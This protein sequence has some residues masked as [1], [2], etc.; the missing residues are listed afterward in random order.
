MGILIEF[1]LFNCS[2]SIC[3]SSDYKSS[4]GNKLLDYILALAPPTRCNG[5][6]DSRLYSGN[7]LKGRGKITKKCKLLFLRLTIYSKIQLIWDA[8]RF[9]YEEIE[10]NLNR[11]VMLNGFTT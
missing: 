5:Y 2:R 4:S 8:G 6:A 11:Y 3:Y 7:I 9:E 10:L 1:I